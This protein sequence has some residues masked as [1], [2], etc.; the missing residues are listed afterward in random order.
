[1]S[2]S[3]G[4]LQTAMGKWSPN[5]GALGHALPGSKLIKTFGAAWRPLVPGRTRGPDGASPVRA[6]EPFCS[7]CPGAVGPARYWKADSRGL[8]H[9]NLGAPSGGL[10]AVEPVHQAMEHRAE[11]PAAQNRDFWPVESYQI[12]LRLAGRAN[13][14]NLMAI[15]HRGV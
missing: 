6:N 3:A 8:D 14:T 5:R 2:K 13:F 15:M 9:G 10:F 7:W 4:V 12:S 11:V 1:M